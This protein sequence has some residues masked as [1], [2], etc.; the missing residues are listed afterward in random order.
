MSGDFVSYESE[1]VGDTERDR[2]G[3]TSALNEIR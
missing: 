1:R 2:T 3:M